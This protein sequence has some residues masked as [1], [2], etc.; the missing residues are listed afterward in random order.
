MSYTCN[1]CHRSYDHHFRVGNKTDGATR[2]LCSNDCYQAWIGGRQTRRE[3]QDR[4]GS[5][6]LARIFISKMFGR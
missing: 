3:E 5:L 4:G 2:T 1:Q 6:G